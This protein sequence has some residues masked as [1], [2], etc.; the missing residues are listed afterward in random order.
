MKSLLNCGRQNARIVKMCSTL[1]VTDWYTQHPSEPKVGPPSGPAY[2]D[3]WGHEV[4]VPPPRKAK[5][6]PRAPPRLAY[7]V[8]R[9]DP[10]ARQLYE[11]DLVTAEYLG[12]P[13]SGYGQRAPAPRQQVASAGDISGGFETGRDFAVVSAE[14]ER[15]PS[16]VDAVPVTTT[17]V[18]AA[19]VPRV[20]GVNTPARRSE[21]G[22][23]GSARGQS[24][25]WVATIPVS[26]IGKR[27]KRRSTGATAGESSATAGRA[28]RS[29]AGSERSR[30]GTL[31]EGVEGRV[32]GEGA[33]AKKKAPVKSRV[34]TE[35]E[36]QRRYE[37]QKA[38]V[39]DR[40]LKG[41]TRL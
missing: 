31:A 16:E 9:E 41:M 17:E 3:W 23:P 32:G 7:S 14:G 24:A 10:R 37:E 27:P 33:A 5:R 39:S 13:G 35:I 1:F 12:V 11:D 28:A 40:I 18:G 22:D 34:R 15:R 6:P 8:P 38:A 4:F 21:A 2:P 29:E 25:G 30:R 19:A 36:A 20:S 26:E